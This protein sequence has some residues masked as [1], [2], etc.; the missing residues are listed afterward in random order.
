MSD[1]NQL[2]DAA[3]LQPRMEPGI[4]SSTRTG[5]NVKYY[6]YTHSFVGELYLTGEGRFSVFAMTLRNN[7][8][9]LP[10]PFCSGVQL[11]NLWQQEM[12]TGGLAVTRTIGVFLP[13]TAEG[14]FDNKR[15]SF[16]L[17]RLSFYSGF[18]MMESTGL[19][20]GL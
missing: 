4:N 2:V 13:V 14:F 20:A 19:G 3:L 6:L 15:D 10:Q 8:N 18:E 17:S 16:F 12:N 5:L 7:I 1:V 11:S 9:N